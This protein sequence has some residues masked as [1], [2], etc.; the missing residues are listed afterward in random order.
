MPSIAARFTL[1]LAAI[2]T[3]AQVPQKPRLYAVRD[4]RLSAP[5]DAPRSTLILRDGRIERVLDGSGESPADARIVDGKGMLALP[6]FVDA[7]TQTGCPTP[8]PNA[9]RDAPPKASVEALVDMREANRKGIQPSFR[10]AEAFRLEPDAGKKWRSFGYGSML[11]APGGQFLAGQ[12]AFASTRDAPP[13]DV[14]VD[15]VVF[16]H[17]SFEAPGPGYPGTLMGAVAQLRQ[18]FLDARRQRELLSRREVGKSGPRPPF[19]ADFE[20]IAPTLQK[21]RR[22]FCEADTVG[23]IDRWIRLADEFGFEIGIVGGREAWKRASVLQKRSIPV[24]L[25]LDWGEEV[26]DPHAKDKKTPL[27]KA[28]TEKPSPEKPATEKPPT[29]KP[30]PE[31]PPEAPKPETPPPSESPPKPEAPVK[32]DAGENEWKFEDS[33]RVREEKR[34]LW[35]ETRNDAIRLGEAGVTI[36]FGTGKSSPKEILERARTLVEKGMP[37]KLALES[38]TSN[39]AA[40]LG[41]GRA[42]GRI[43]PGYA[44]SIAL[45]TADPLASKDAKVAWLFVDGFPHEFDVRPEPALEGKPDAGVDAT[46]TWAFEFEG[47][48][49][50]PATAELSMD[51]EG[52]VKAKFRFK[53]PNEE[54]D[55]VGD[56]EG[57]VAGKKIRLS[58]KVKFGNSDVDV[59]VEGEIEK[60]E[61]KGKALLKF[62]NREDSRPYTATRKTP[63]E[64][65]R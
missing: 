44:A 10:A 42:Y 49:A 19:D 33:L 40:I 60:D 14:L 27:E 24:I 13:R 6:A 9:E 41:E 39:A 31:K 64:D 54:A 51:K 21:R 20:A 65:L 48:R 16:Q 22:L 37:A 35:E 1:A 34:R 11:A 4:V 23:D 47:P 18:F 56:F 28:T 45:W 7:Y 32:S 25:T 62:P 55:R 38:L 26:E 59:V 12:S 17:G 58:G 3:P 52:V 29:E 43:E 50:R 2:P 36:A 53:A 61:I 15:P 46:G 63:K 57:K 8:T 5:A 30:S